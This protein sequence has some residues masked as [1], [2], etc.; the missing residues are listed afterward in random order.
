VAGESCP[1]PGME[2]LRLRLASR[3]GART[4][5]RPFSARSPVF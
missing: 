4:C 2:P 3:A 5:P 1:E